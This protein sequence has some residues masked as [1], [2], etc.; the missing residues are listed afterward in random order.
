MDKKQKIINYISSIEDPQKLELLL[1]LFE[2]C[3]V[4]KN[5]VKLPSRA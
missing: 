4:E 3:M 1:R 5:T 2:S